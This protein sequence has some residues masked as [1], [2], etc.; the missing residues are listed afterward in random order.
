MMQLYTKQKFLYAIVFKLDKLYL[1]LSWHR[2]SHQLLYEFRLSFAHM[3]INSEAKHVY[4]SIQFFRWPS[5][6]RNKHWR[7]IEL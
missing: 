2:F 4:Y 6:N 1:K 3:I 5:N 7:N